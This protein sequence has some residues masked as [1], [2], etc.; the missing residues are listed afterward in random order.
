[1]TAIHLERTGGLAACDLTP[2]G[3]F[4]SSFQLSSQPPEPARCVN[5]V[6]QARQARQ[7]RHAGL[8]GIYIVI[9]I[10]VI[11]YDTRRQR[12]EFNS[13]A[14][15]VP[16]VMGSLVLLVV[17]AAAVSI[18][19]SWLKFVS[20]LPDPISQAGLGVGTWFAAGLPCLAYLLAKHPDRV[21]TGPVPLSIFP[22]FLIDFN[23]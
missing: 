22:I 6:S 11:G 7:A 19:A 2:L 23:D 10:S 12:A 9:N 21:R 4:M 15:L 18:G 14:H 13:L 17:L 1:M 5:R 20:P 16:P 3:A 8:I